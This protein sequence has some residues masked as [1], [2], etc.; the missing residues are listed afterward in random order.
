M[1][2]NIMVFAFAV[3]VIVILWAVSKEPKEVVSD[4]IKI[5]AILSL[6]GPAAP[7]GEINREALQ[8][9]EEE[10]N[11]KGGIDGR[12]VEIIIEDDG[13]SGTKAASAFQKLVDSEK[14]DVVIGGMWDFIAQAIMPLAEERGVVFISPSNFR[15]PD[16]FEPN[17]QTFLMLP[18]FEFA[19]RKLEGEI[20]KSEVEK[21]AL[22]RFNSSFGEEIG[23]S[24]GEI[25]VELGHGPIMTETYQ[26]IGGNDYRTTI[27]KLKDQG[28][29]GVYLDMIGSDTVTFLR[30]AKEMKFTPKI[31]THLG[32]VEDFVINGDLDKSLLENVIVLDWEVSSPEFDTL[33]EEKYGH[34][35]GK[36]AN[37]TYDAVYASAEAIAKKSANEMLFEYLEDHKFET[38]NGTVDF[39]EDHT[40]DTI[41][42]AVYIVTNGEFIPK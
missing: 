25:S 26:S 32:A 28:I 12:M 1:K 10:I 2:R 30:Q 15:I 17:K 24:L 37:R 31:F 6:S 20:A 34:A 38:L 35:P 29:D 8:L 42:T 23:R 14:V 41:E 16:V 36:S 40:V 33:F 7:F 11:K 39:N 9:A 18:D 4:P 13:T 21:L 27:A 19:I 5:G 3:L 22:V